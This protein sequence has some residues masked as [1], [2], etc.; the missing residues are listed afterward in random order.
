MTIESQIVNIYYSHL[1]FYLSLKKS[2]NYKSNV[3]RYFFDLLMKA[4]VIILELLFTK[5][6][7]TNQKTKHLTINPRINLLMY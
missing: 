7:Y 5:L 4:L 1:N 6:T 3:S 2:H